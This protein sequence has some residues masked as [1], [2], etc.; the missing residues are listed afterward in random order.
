[1][2]KEQMHSTAFKLINKMFI[3][4]PDGYAENGYEPRRG[5]LGADSHHVWKANETVSSGELLKLQKVQSKNY[6]NL[7][8]LM[9][10]C[11]FKIWINWKISHK[12]NSIFI[13][14]FDINVSKELLAE[15]QKIRGSGSQLLHHLY[16]AL[17]VSYV[18][19]RV[20]LGALVA[21][22]YTS[23]PPRCTASQYRR[24]FIPISIHR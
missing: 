10:W 8:P 11:H 4:D 23:G 12:F 9:L 6:L 24:T 3:N 7:Q 14:K 21:H 16:V 5:L 2:Q 15:Q 20:T 13:L 22:R 18:P 17:P 19:V 1:M